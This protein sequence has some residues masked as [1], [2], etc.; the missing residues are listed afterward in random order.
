MGVD[1]FGDKAVIRLLVGAPISGMDENQQRAFRSARWKQVERLAGYG[2]VT[3]IFPPIKVRLGPGARRG[4]AVA[5]GLMIRMP[6]A[7]VVFCLRA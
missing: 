1:G 4:P 6:G 2:A 3:H 7:D 5:H